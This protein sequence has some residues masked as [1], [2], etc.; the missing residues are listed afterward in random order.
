MY[1][2]GPQEL[3]QKLVFPAPAVVADAPVDASQ[4]QHDK[5]K[6]QN[7][8]QFHQEQYCG[9]GTRCHFRHEFRSFTK[10]HRHY[11]MCQIAALPAR[12]AGLF[13][14]AA[15]TVT[16][17][18]RLPVFAALREQ[19]TDEPEAAVEGKADV[20]FRWEETA[21]TGIFSSPVRGE[22]ASNY[23]CASQS[24][25]KHTFKARSLNF[26]DLTC[27][28]TL[29]ADLALKIVTDSSD[30]TSETASSDC[31]FG[32]VASPVNLLGAAQ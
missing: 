12:E 9:Y 23:L 16:P 11:Y 27:K 25:E 31:S 29:P 10:I 5:Y 13:D 28:Q 18:K 21:S 22:D 2:H 24:A 14:S 1:A 6:S 7:C 26:A 17:A 3:S 32:P 19:F 30:A 15:E 4:N 8:R 20:G